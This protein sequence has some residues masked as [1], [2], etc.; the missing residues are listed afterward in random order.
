[1]TSYTENGGWSPDKEQEMYNF[2]DDLYKNNIKFA[3]SNVL[4]YRDKKNEMLSN[5]SH[6]YNIHNLDY[7]YINN[8]SHG[9]D[10]S[11]ETQEVLITNY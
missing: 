5:W 3:L 10:N 9:K 6:K 11:A 4:I 2:V 7:K 8:N 1:V